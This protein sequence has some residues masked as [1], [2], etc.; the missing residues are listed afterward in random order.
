MKM[1]TVDD[2]APMRRIIKN[3]LKQVGFEEVDEAVSRATPMSRA[4]RRRCRR[5]STTSGTSCR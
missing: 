4:A 1:L 5:C 2:S 3:Q